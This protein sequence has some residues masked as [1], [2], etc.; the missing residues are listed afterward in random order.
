VAVQIHRTNF[1]GGVSFQLDGALPPGVTQSWYQNP[2]A[3][4][5]GILRLVIPS[6]L[7]LGTYSFTVRGSAPGYADQTVTFQVPVVLLSTF[8][9]KATPD[10][11]AT[12]KGGTVASSITVD[13]INFPGDVALSLDYVPPGLTAML[14][15]SLLSGA[16][17]STITIG[18][19]PNLQGTG[20]MS[21]SVRAQSDTVVSFA[22]VSL[23]IQ[24]SPIFGLGLPQSVSIKQ[25]SSATL[26][27]DPAR[28]LYVGPVDLSVTGTPPGITVSF[29][30]NP[31][32]GYTT[33]T[34]T[35][36]VAAGVPVGQYVLTFTGSAPGGVPYNAPL[37]V[38]VTP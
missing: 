2:T 36:S 1:T 15:T 18:V 33:T 21:V 28:T 24:D 12:Y 13:R 16:Q 19:A 8:Y 5:V 37:T 22:R 29:A 23:V 10:R 34:S 9:L 31:V 32:S 30:Q 3:T 38:N 4:N 26:T 6:D 25:G 20:G 7:P 17:S 11:H 27:V 35:I 14:S